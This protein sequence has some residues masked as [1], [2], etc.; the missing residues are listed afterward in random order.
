MKRIGT[1]LITLL[2][3]AAGSGAA[4]EIRPMQ[5]EP[6]PELNIPRSGHVLLNL[7][8]ELT[9]IGGHTTGFVPTATAEY[10]KDGQWHT[11]E[12]LYPHDFAIC[13]TLPGGEVLVAGGMT[14][15]FGV[16]GSI[17]A[18]LYNPATHSFSPLPILDRSRSRG[19]AAV[20]TD[21]TIV[22]SGNWYGEDGIASYSLQKGGG[23]IKEALQQRANPYILPCAPD[24]ALIFSVIDPYDNYTD[25]VLVER[26]RGE[27]L[28]DA[29]LQEWQ[30]VPFESIISSDCLA[31][32]NPALGSY[33]ALLPARRAADGQTGILKQVGERFSLLE[34]EDPIP[35]TGTDGEAITWGRLYADKASGQAW[36]VS[37][38]Q[39]AERLY[40][41]RIGYQEALDGGKAPVQMFAADNFTRS[42]DLYCVL[43]D[44]GRIAFVGGYTED[45]YN[46]SGTAF[47][48][49]TA[50]LQK[51]SSL[52]I[53]PFLILAAAICAL[54]LGFVLRK[55]P[56]AP[57]PAPKYH[58]SIPSAGADLASR[59][60]TLVEGEQLFRRKGLK[61]QDIAAELGTNVTYISAC[62][63]GQWGMSF[64]EYLNGLR[65][66]YAK[67]QMTAG[68][69]KP[70][71]QI[72]D[73]AG[74]S[75]E[76]SFYRIF[77]AVTGVTP[78]EWLE[79][80]K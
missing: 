13:T 44:G 2:L 54:V 55:K 19:S 34:A 11:V 14:E 27:P 61:V 18:E 16:G 48:L 76:Q 28:T 26:F 35:M 59:I 31:I 25:A 68:P 67:E 38:A 70:L 52:P 42:R 66:R 79:E 22:V 9:V 12:S 24:N 62:I 15:P 6:L 4:Q 39:R 45:N 3:L 49:H 23:R 5:V 60:A 46:P 10:L 30:P 53:W 20:L 57:S 69:D 37:V 40:V 32:G 43:M 36:L 21:G 64:P 8:G 77:K 65:L 41:C 63:N 71:H 73:E 50:P 78:S 72:A 7:D 17:G 29:L 58:E 1:A 33:A 74:F 47:I 80:M 56:S 75:S 51:A